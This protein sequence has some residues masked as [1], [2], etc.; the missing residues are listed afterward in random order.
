VPDRNATARFQILREVFDLARAQRAHLEADRMEVVLDLMD[1]R[2]ALMARLEQLLVE[3]AEVPDNVIAF[4]S[5]A[6][7]VWAEQDELALDT[8]IRGI[9]EHD[10][11]NEHILAEKMDAVRG[12]LPRLQDGLRAHAGYRRQMDGGALIDRVS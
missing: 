10:Q 1:Q 3:H 7:A 6:T 8:L 12:E 5:A 2:D 11:Q 4:P 9:L